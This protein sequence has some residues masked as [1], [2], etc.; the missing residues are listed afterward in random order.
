MKSSTDQGPRWITSSEILLYY[1]F[2]IFSRYLKGENAELFVFLLTKKNTT[3]SPD[4][5][6]QRF[7]NLQRAALLGSFW[8]NITKFFSKFGQKQLV[9][10]NYGCDFNQPERGNILNE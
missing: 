6:G 9:M 7:N 3:S 10:V 4:F 2:K 5:L 1:L 8:F